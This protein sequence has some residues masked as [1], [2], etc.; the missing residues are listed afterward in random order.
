M[1]VY[2]DITR[3]DLEALLGHYRLGA[4]SGFRGIAA[5]VVNSNFFVDTTHGRYVLTVFET[6]PASELPYFLNLTH[7][8]AARGIACPDPVADGGGRVLQEL[9]GK[10]AALVHCLPGA[11]L[12][13][14]DPAAC[15]LAGA[16]LAALHLAGADFGERRPNPQGLDWARGCRD[17]LAGVLAGQDSDLLDEELRFQAESARAGLP[18]GVIHGDLFHDN[19]LF[20]QGRI[21]GIIDFYYACDDVLLLDLAIAVNDWCA[22]DDGVLDQARLRAMLGAYA[23]VRPVAGTEL[24]LWPV[25]LRAAALR[26]WVSRLMDKYFP[27]SGSLTTIK[28]PDE[29]RD[30][31]RLRREADEADHSLWKCD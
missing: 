3:A 18:R 30:I 8:L 23:R 16:A 22:G 29:Y 2:T 12:E 17:Q 24:A 9:H 21:S 26:F 27:R 6:L 5:G 14:V 7:H 1:A 25:M 15:A 4:L 19:V 10:P 11:H 13:T 20:E 28:D 31:L